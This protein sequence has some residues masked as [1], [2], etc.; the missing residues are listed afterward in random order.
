MTIKKNHSKGTKQTISMAI[1][2]AL[3]IVI[4][5]P[6]GAQWATNGNDINN[7]NT[8]NVGVGTTTPGVKLEVKVP[9]ISS[10]VASTTDLATSA[11]V[12]NG[13]GGVFSSKAGIIGS[14]GNTGDISSGLVF[15][16]EGPN[17][18][19]YVSFNTHPNNTSNIKDFFERM[20]IN[21]DGSVGIGTSSP[22]TQFHLAVTSSSNPRGMT[23][24]Q[25]TD[26]A[27]SSI[28]ALAKSRGTPT[29]P[30]A[31]LNGD[32]IGSV[33]S[34]AYDGTSYVLGSRMRFAV[35][36]AVTTGNIPTSIQFLTGAGGA[37]EKMRITSAGNVGIGTSNPTYLLDVMGSAGSPFR[38]LDSSSREYFSTAT[39]TG[40]YGTAPVASLGGG[41]LMIDSDGPLGG[42]STLLRRVVNSLI[43]SPSDNPGFPGAVIMSQP[44]GTSI[45]YVDQNP[46]GRVGVGTSGP[47]FK[48]DVQGG[49]VNA[50]GGLCI[51]GDCKTAWSQLGSQWT[52]SGTN[53]SYSA[54]NVGIGTTTTPS[55][56]LQVNGDLTVSGTG[57]ISATGTISGG[58]V[59][60]TYQ[61]IAEWVSASNPLPAGT[62]VVLDTEKANHVIASQQAYDTRVA[63]VISERP[64]VILGQAA[65]SKVMVATTGRVRVKVDATLT[66]IHVG[67]ILV[68]SDKEGIAM[69]S[70]PIDVAGV[71]IHR[72]GTIIGKALEPFAN[73]TGEVLVLLSLQ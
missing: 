58:N 32:L 49:Q 13:G 30:T 55:S 23:V 26:D 11:I 22:L 8:G 69:R 9:T 45:L 64:G 5:Q 10:T 61:D 31:V 4:A 39:H 3:S 47:A 19:T 56:K 46:G 59:V 29:A 16:R 71:K 40:P 44:D 35:D 50:S 63:G 33:F 54:G 57:N 18:G 34:Q 14:F 67:D 38:V 62:V 7:T 53:I 72:P 65:P 51:A 28:F 68:T 27:Q 60:A 1:L 21:M 36:G 37:N 52:T 70:E 25:H 20:R 17:W 41:R 42:N 15:G 48:L 73:G 43:I 66:P 6:A 12:I 24:S 2:F